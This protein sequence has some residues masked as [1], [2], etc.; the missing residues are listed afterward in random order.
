LAVRAQAK[1]KPLPISGFENRIREFVNQIK[2]VDT[3]EHLANPA[4]LKKSGMLD[5]MLLLHIEDALIFKT[6]SNY[7]IDH[8][9]SWPLLFPMTKSAVKAMDVI[10]EFSQEQVS[11]DITGFVV[12]G[13]STQIIHTQNVI[14][15][16]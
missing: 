3:H 14:T 10:Q 16:L 15:R 11:K 8:D 6:L 13:A 9:F 1:I 5:F 12:A 7:L 2:I 4:A